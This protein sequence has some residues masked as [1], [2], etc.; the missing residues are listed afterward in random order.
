MPAEYPPE[1][2]GQYLRQG[3]WFVNAAGDIDGAAFARELQRLLKQRNV[4]VN[5]GRQQLANRH[6]AVFQ[7]VIDSCNAFLLSP[8]WNTVTP[9]LPPSK[10]PTRDSAA[11]LA[12]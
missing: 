4:A 1:R 7:Q 5:V 10:P 6:I 8:M 12:R 9:G 3:D 11:I 2:R